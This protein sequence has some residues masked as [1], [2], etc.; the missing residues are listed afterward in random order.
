MV[1]RFPF[2]FP[3]A[4]GEM[5]LFH[6]ISARCGR[7]THFRFVLDKTSETMQIIDYSGINDAD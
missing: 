7:W 5:L 1:I 2:D 6:R 4:A 3:E